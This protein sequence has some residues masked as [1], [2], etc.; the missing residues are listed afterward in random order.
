M[1]LKF[2]RLPRK[3]NSR[4]LLLRDYLPKG[5]LPTPP[6][7]VGYEYA[8]SDA[9]WAQS[10]LGNDSVGDC[11]EAMALHFIMAAQSNVGSRV[12]FTS[13]QA[14]QLYSAITGYNPSDPSTDQGTAITDLLAYWQSTGIYGH[15]ILAWAAVNPS[16]IAQVRAA[17][18]LFGGL[19]A[20]IEVT[21]GMMTQF[22]ANQPWNAPFTGPVEG[23]HGIPILGYGRA[24]Q[25]CITWARRQQCDLNFWQLVDELYVVCT[26]DW[27]NAQGQS[28][29]GL[30]LEALQADLKLVA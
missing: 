5:G 28:P 14:I 27:I 15:K 7:A 20:G 12:T 6:Q 2:G 13:D 11:V 23:G 3:F 18:Y 24:G 22:S 29:S 8:V 10:M 30:N 16:D 21:S 17:A 26:E 19:L 4:T 25:T 1:P 9:T